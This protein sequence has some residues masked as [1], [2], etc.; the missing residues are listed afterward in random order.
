MSQVP[1]GQPRGSTAN[2]ENTA[3]ERRG[4]TGEASPGLRGTR[5]DFATAMLQNDGGNQ[6]ELLLLS[7]Q[8]GTSSS[9][10]GLG[11][12]KRPC[13]T[14]P[15]VHHG[16]HFGRT[17]R[18]FC[19]VQTLIK[20][21]ISRTLRMEYDMEENNLESEDMPGGASQ[22]DP[23]PRQDQER[24][25]HTIFK[26]LLDLCPGL[27]QRL[28]TGSEEEVFHVAELIQKGSSTARADDTKG[29]KGVI[30]DW[31]TPRGHNLEPP[32]MRNVKTDRGF[33]HDRTGELLCPVGLD[34]KDKATRDGLRAGTIV[35]AG[36][37]WPFFVYE[38]YTFDSTDVWKGLFR[39]TLLVWAF[40]HIFT[41]PS[42]V[43]R[44]PRATR[45]G[46]ARIHGMTQVTVPSLAYVA[47]QVRFALSSSPVFSRTD[48]VTDSERFYTSV[49]DGFTDKAE[50]EHVKELLI[51]W[52][53]QI[54][55]AENRPQNRTLK[56][57]SVL[58]LM[59]AQRE[60]RSA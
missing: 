33:Y 40:K 5:R 45:S 29:L 10:L 47:T 11:P 42:S 20:N 2:K 8:G 9:A 19:R 52:N 41:S 4:F 24:Q 48:L 46:N 53:S 6:E 12:R 38:N 30:I 59:K 31:I 7:P 43:D 49:I 55:P 25:E 26:Q 35:V 39:S 22:S 51:W 14:D 60:A 56:K 58:A 18:A 21:G 15:L 54:F 32:L 50:E 23:D 37:D 34:W 3:P 28:F 57:G 17:I 16:R 1:Q 44:E 13:R 36:D 27:E